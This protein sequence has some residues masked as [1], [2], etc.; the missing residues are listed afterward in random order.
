MPSIAGLPETT[1]DRGTGHHMDNGTG[2]GT[3]NDSGTRIART[4]RIAANGRDNG[5]ARW[6]G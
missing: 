5:R 4:I 6:A 1:G 3:E 2:K